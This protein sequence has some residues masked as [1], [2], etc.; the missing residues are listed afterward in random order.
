VSELEEREWLAR[1]RAHREWNQ[2]EIGQLFVAFED[3]TARAWQLD[4]QDRV[5]GEQLAEAWEKQ[6][7][8][9]RALVKAIGGPDLEGL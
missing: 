8:A 5:G 3:A 1:Y 2:T 6:S 7:E 9:R 4:S